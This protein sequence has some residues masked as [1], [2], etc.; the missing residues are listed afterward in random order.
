MSFSSMAKAEMARVMPR[1]RCC[2]E[3]ELTALLG[4]D[5]AIKA[6]GQG[7]PAL[8][9]SSQSAGVARKIFKLSKLLLQPLTI[10]VAV[11]R[12]RNLKKQNVYHVFIPYQAGAAEL[13]APLGLHFS[14]D[15]WSVNWEPVV[16]EKRCCRKA[17]LRGAF[18]GGGSVNDPEGTY[19]LEV[20]TRD[21][22]HSQTICKV[23]EV[24]ELNPRISERKQYQVIYLKESDQIVQFL[25]VVGA[26]RALLD[27]ESTR[28]VKDMRNRVNRLVNCETANLSKTVETGVRQ[29]EMIRLLEDRMGLEKL[30]LPL[31]E[32]A[33]LRLEFPD[34]SLREL[35]QMLD[36]PVGKS[37]ANHRLRKLEEMAQELMEEEGRK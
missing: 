19:H 25:N 10:Q 26:H 15:G 16:L 32:I 28:V 13:L 14:E 12:K 20:I 5:G 36:P 9:M 35:G 24:F 2:Q 17:Y 33:R 23:M 31:R 22:V 27:F 6:T 7:E 3:A 4:M 30:P 21:Q 11:T 8:V 18:L 29:V 37:G 34:A 1:R